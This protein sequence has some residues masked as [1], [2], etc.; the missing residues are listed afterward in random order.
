MSKILKNH[1]AKVVN[2]K[3]E[4]S[5]VDGW[6]ADVKRH[7]GKA[8]FVTVERI[9]RQRSIPQNSYYFGIVI[10]CLMEWSGYDKDEMHEALKEKFL[11][12]EKVEGLPSTRSTADLTTIEFMDYIDE[13]VRWAATQGVDIPEPN[14]VTVKDNFYTETN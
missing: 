13:I 10:P 4:F 14:E 9:F 12:I 8:V 1:F 7:E 6:K 5:D 11:R 2:G 3:V